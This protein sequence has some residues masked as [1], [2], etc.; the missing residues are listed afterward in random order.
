M[1]ALTA[2]HAVPNATRRI[3]VTTMPSTEKGSSALNIA[4][5]FLYV[6]TASW[7]ADTPPYQG[8][9]VIIDL[10]RGT[11]HV[12]NGV[13]SDRTHLL[14]PASAATTARAFGPGLAWWRIP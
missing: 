13:C 5:G 14:A 9:L 12:F 6:T 3:L 10:T 8:H 4:D 1:A 11:T 7:G 2:K